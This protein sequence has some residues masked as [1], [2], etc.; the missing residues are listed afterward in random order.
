MGKVEILFRVV[1]LSYI[2]IHK[3][4]VWGQQERDREK[5]KERESET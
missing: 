1:D 3:N 5:G 4:D 2:I